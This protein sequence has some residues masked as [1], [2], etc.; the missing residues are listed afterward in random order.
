MTLEFYIGQLLYRYNCVVVPNFGSF[1][2]S[3]KGAYVDK[4]S[5]TFYP[6]TKQLLFNEHLLS[7][8]GLL[9]SYIAESENKSYEEVLNEIERKVNNWNK[10]IKSG[11]RIILD[12]IGDLWLNKGGKIQFQPS[13]K[14]NFLTSSFGLTSFISSPVNREVYKDETEK[15]EENIPFI[16]TPERKRKQSFRYL[17]KYAAILLLAFSAGLT[18]YQVYYRTS[19]IKAIAEQEA[20]KI[21]SKNI[22]EATFFNSSPLEFPILEIPVIKKSTASHHIIAGAFRVKENADKKMKQLQKDGY[23]ASYIGV[24]K[25]GLHQV[26]YQSFENPEEAL[27]MLR[28]IKENVSSDA[29]LLSVK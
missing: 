29:W 16:I 27:I 7:N 21:V 17:A 5:S 4:S 9:I 28:E 20:Q 8:D 6:P 23:N 10:Q 14:V 18:T 2:T 13:N 25:Y 11:K 26:A 12:S 19:S 24:N 22:Q 3:R 1:L 15:L